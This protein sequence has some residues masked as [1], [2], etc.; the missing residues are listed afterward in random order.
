MRKIKFIL[1]SLIVLLGLAVAGLAIH[2]RISAQKQKSLAFDF[3]TVADFSLVDQ[4]GDRIT[5]DSLKGQMWIASFIFTRCLGP[6]PLMSYKIA[7]LQKEI[8]ASEKIQ[9]ISFSVDPEYDTPAVLAKYAASYNADPARWHFLTGDKK[10]VYEMI[11]NSFKLAVEE[12]T[13]KEVKDT[14]FV[15]STLF[16]L[17]DKGGVIRG[18]YNSV[19]NE[20]VEKLRKDIKQWM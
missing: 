4:T 2:N 8:P 6:C 16:V 20:A 19:E 1:R 9:F 11:R 7:Q 5:R 17:V 12:V 10:S 14:D 18:Y 3:G 15:H 13:G